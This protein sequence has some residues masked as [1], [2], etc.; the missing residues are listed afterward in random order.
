[1]VKLLKQE[2]VKKLLNIG[3]RSECVLKNIGR[4]LGSQIL[5][6]FTEFCTQG[7]SIVIPKVD[8]NV[9]QCTFA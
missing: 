1:M 9:Q 8:L 6:N 2:S 5:Q 7:W 3:Y 4:K